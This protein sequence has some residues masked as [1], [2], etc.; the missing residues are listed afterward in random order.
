MQNIDLDS[1]VYIDSQE[2]LAD[3]CQQW[4]KQNHLALDTEFVRTNTFYPRFGLLQVADHSHCYLID[5]LTIDNWECFTE[6][7]A[8]KDLCFILHSCGEDLNLFASLFRLL[9]AR[10]FDTQIAA[11]FLGSGFSISYQGLVEDALGIT[12]PKSETRSDWLRRPLSQMQLHYAA[13]DVAYLLDLRELQQDRLHEHGLQ[14]W[15]EGECANL[16]RMAAQTEQRNTWQGMY[17]NISNAWRLDDSALQ[18]LQ[19]LCVWRELE[20]RE[21]DKPRNWIAK[22]GELFLIA[23]NIDGNSATIDQLFDLELDKRM[24][25]RYG[26]KILSALRDDSLSDGMPDRSRLNTP[27]SGSERKLLKAGQKLVQEKAEQVGMA[28]EI[29]GRK[30]WLIELIQRYRQ[31][32]SFLESQHG[33][34]WR[35]QILNPELSN[36]LS[37]QS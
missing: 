19:R 22:D 18:R 30:R 35:M 4:S 1:A 21:R 33:G 25:N 5:P 24:L 26:K 36:I 8:S 28:P 23:N 10:I 14:Q 11:A 13:A 34:D 9:P 16:L 37:G 31:H 2:H 15:F 17:A 7:F 6:L 27:L 3:C 12:L 32:G 29:L 20:A